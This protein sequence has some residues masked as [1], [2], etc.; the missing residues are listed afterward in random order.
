[1]I[2]RDP[3]YKV[4]QPDCQLT[5]IQKLEHKVIPGT[6]QKLSFRIKIR[7]KRILGLERW[8]KLKK[9]I[10]YFL[11]SSH[12]KNKKNI[13]TQSQNIAH[14][15]SIIFKPG[16]L[17]RIKSKEEIEQTLDAWRSLKGCAFMKEM[18]KYCNTVQRVLKPVERFTDERDFKIKSVSGLVLLEG[19]MC[20][21]TATF[22]RCDRSC[23]YFWRVEWLEKIENPSEKNL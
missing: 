21:G 8:R 7:L 18:E 20:E 13:I 15:E 19:L 22:G 10:G 12:R 3:S 1:M 5:N 4:L 11:I 16:D 17:V 9:I 6:Y 2:Q 14:N 23:F